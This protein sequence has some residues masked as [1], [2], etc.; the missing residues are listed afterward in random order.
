M[1]RVG[2]VLLF[3]AVALWSQEVKPS[4]TLEKCHEDQQLWLT[5]LES[6]HGVEQVTYMQL[7]DWWHEMREC[8]AS[9]PVNHDQ[10]YNTTSEIQAAEQLRLIDY[11]DRHNLLVQFVEEDAAGE[12]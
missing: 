9:D 11:L 3:V 6:T 2:T 1:N 8:D 7:G 12:R 4:L 5:R 10:Y